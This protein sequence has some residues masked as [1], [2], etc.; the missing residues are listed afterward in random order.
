MNYITKCHALQVKVVVEHSRLKTA[1]KGTTAEKHESFE[2]TVGFP[3]LTHA[4]EMNLRYLLVE[5]MPLNFTVEL[6]QQ[7]RRT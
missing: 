1:A 5:Q 4:T 3:E 2:K 6:Q 7:L